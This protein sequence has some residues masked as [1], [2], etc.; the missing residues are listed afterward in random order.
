MVALGAAAPLIGPSLPVSAY[1]LAA[2][3]CVLGGISWGG[4]GLAQTGVTLHFADGQGRSKYVAASAVL[5]S[6]G[7]AMGGLLGG[8]M[9]QSLEFLRTHPIVLGPFEWNHWHAA[10]AVSLVVRLA[11]LG[12]L[13]HMPDPGARPVRYV[14]RYLTANVSNAVSGRLFYP[15]RVFGWG[16]RPRPGA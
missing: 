9:V 4:V 13:V 14:L 2:L 8:A 1:L 6:I 5:I 10:F 3:G 15:L 12:W 7:G 16:R 11:S